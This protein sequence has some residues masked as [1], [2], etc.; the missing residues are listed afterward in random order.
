MS[1]KLK[2]LMVFGLLAGAGLLAGTMPGCGSDSSSGGTSNAQAL[3]NKV[4]DKVATCLGGG[5]AGASTAA[6]CKASCSSPDGGAQMTCTNEAQIESA[7]N[8]CVNMADCT[9]FLTCALSVPECQMPGGG[10]GG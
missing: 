1:I 5:D 2:T 3:C 6:D 7:A 9:A 10:N 8:A 4:C